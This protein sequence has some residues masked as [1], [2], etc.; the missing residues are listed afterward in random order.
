MTEKTRP[1][2]DQHEKLLEITSEISVYLADSSKI[3]ENSNRISK[4][5]TD[6]LRNLKVHLTLEDT[7]LYPVICLTDRNDMKNIAREYKDEMGD[8]KDLFSAYF[9]RWSSGFKIKEDSAA[10]IEETNLLFDSLS[11]RI[12]REN[13]ELYRIIDEMFQ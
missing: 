2:R 4:L 8:I 13:T 9:D 7:S 10:F 6:L 11:K 12:E 5:L 3:I 1:F